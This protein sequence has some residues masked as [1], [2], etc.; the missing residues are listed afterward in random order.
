MMPT[1]T[2][3]CL[4]LFMQSVQSHTNPPAASLL[5]G[6]ANTCMTYLARLLVACPHQAHG[7]RCGSLQARHPLHRQVQS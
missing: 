3:W 2:S 7:L 5:V 1:R 6:M 4:H